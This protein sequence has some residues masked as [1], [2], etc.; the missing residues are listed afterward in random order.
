MKKVSI[1]VMALFAMALFAPVMAQ[2]DKET[3]KQLEEMRNQIELLKMQKELEAV[4][5]ELEA[6][7]GNL[8]CMR[9]A[10]DD[11]E[12]YRGLGIGEPEDGISKAA[13]RKAALLD[14]KS[15]IRN[16]MPEFVKGV[17]SD[18]ASL[19]GGNKGQQLQSKIENKMN[20]VIEG[21][22]NDAEQICEKMVTT[23]RG[24][25][26]SYICIQISKKEMKKEVTDELKGELGTDFKADQFQKFM[27]ERMEEMV[28]AKENAGY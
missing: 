13:A 3:Q 21:M 19:Y 25:P 22:L 4:K 11:K 18:Y 6:A 14:A 15:N 16:K 7:K 24:T 1:V 12:Y 5:A 23:D 2:T 27:D 20:S 8:P 10:F 17:S 26:Q 28:E 9:E